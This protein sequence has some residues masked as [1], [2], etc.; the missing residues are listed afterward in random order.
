MVIIARDFK[1][2]NW[3]EIEIQGGIVVAVRP[4]EGPSETRPNDDWVGPAFWDI[5]LNG[6]WGHSFSSPELTVEQVVAIVRAQGAL[7]TA[8]L[9]PRH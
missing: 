9:C 1:T 4:G 8:R 6:R 3:I 5:Q 2:A 7:G